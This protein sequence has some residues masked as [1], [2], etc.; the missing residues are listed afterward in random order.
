MRAG[1][2]LAEPRP[3]SDFGQRVGRKSTECA[4]PPPPGSPQHYTFVI[5]A[6]DRAEDLPSNPPLP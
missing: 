5:I 1:L 4:T 3:W 2:A 6:T